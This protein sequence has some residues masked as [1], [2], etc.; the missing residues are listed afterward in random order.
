MTKKQKGKVLNIV[1]LICMVI[2]FLIFILTIMF[3]RDTFHYSTSINGIDCSFLNINDAM[4]K[5]E[6]TMNSTQITFLFADN[7]EYTCLGAYFNFEVNSANPLLG[8]LSTQKDT[9]ENKKEY[10]LTDLYKVDEDVAKEYLG[11]LS[12]F[13][14]ENSSKEPV[15]AYLEWDDEKS[16]FYIVPEEYGNKLDFEEAYNYLLSALR[17]G[18]TVID[19]GGITDITPKI[20]ANST[21]L[22]EQ[23]ENINNVVATTVEYKLHNGDTYK[24]DAKTMKDWV[25]RDDDGNYSIDLESNVTKFVDKLAKEAKYKL[26][27]TKFKATGLGEISVPFGRATY[28]TVDKEKEIE[29]LTKQ[30]EIK[31]SAEFEVIYEALPDY[32]NIDTYVELDLSRQRVWMYV[33]GECVLETPCVTGNVAQGYSTPAGIYYLT[34]KTMHATLEGYNYD[35]STYSTPVTYWMPFN[36]GIGFH[37]AT[38]RGSFGGNIYMTNGSHGCVNLPYW[39]AST[40]Y[41]YIN[42]S[43]P[44]ILY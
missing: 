18:K 28:A 4:K 37:D 35:G 16:K 13:T 39:A 36:G 22:K 29:R 19:F 21:E 42:T 8:I 2:I 14:N 38:W 12:V 11:S 7:K 5:L 23:M 44:I 10:N 33:N 20:T 3:M 15:N 9:D 17:N 32:T 6:K 30:L 41:S 34:Y 27:S 1:V 43:I 24:L 40:L 31:K 26:T 25:S